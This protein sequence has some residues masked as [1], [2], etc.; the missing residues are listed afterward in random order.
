MDFCFVGLNGKIS[1]GIFGSLF[2]V[3]GISIILLDEFG[4]LYLF[5]FPRQRICLVNLFWYYEFD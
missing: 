3:L 4:L 1:F 2:L 5:Q